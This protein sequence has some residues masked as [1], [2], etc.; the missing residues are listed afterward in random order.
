MRSTCLNLPRNLVLK[1]LSHLN[2]LGDLPVQGFQKADLS[3]PAH[4]PNSLEADLP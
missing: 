4:G 3:R 1:R 2:L